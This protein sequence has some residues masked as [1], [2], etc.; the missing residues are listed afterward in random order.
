MTITVNTAGMSHA[1]SL[2]AAGKVNT[3]SDWSFSADD[4]NALLGPNGDNWTA[5]GQMHLALDSEADDTTKDHYKYPFG[6]GGQVYRSGLIAIRQRAGQQGQTNVFDAAGTLLELI[7]GK[8]SMEKKS[9]DC[10]F[11]IKAID[12]FGVFEGYGSVFGVKDSYNDIVLPGA[13]SA[14]LATHKKNGTMPALLWQHDSDDLIGVYLEMREDSVGLYVKGRLALKTE[15]GND[16]YELMR[17]YAESGQS[18]GLSIGYVTESDEYDSTTGITKLTAID[19]WEVSVVTFPANASARVT[20]VKSV[21]E[22]ADLKSAEQYLRDAGLSRKEA[23]A[24]VSRMKGLLLRDA[25][26]GEMK[27]IADA[28]KQ[29]A[30]AIPLQ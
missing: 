19:L 7:D 3:A 21:E 14:S 28:L 18:L 6:K 22:I 9:R 12:E 26:N 23:T 10:K 25:D 2:I 4:G 13:F 27:A 15:K 8:K 11:E 30:A 20:G 5:Y 17:M 1:R 24:F 29:R 16:A